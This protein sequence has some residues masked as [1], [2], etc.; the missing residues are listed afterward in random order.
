MSRPDPDPATLVSG[1]QSWD[2][3]LRDL[4]DAVLKKP[5]PLAQYA[6]FGSLPAAGSYDRCL[7]CT[8]NGNLYWS[9]GGS[10]VEIY[11]GS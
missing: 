4:L 3:T 5:F 11:P 8:A 10:W 6:D 1:Q 9:T 7:A 2:A